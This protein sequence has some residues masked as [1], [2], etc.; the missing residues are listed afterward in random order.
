MH[1][2]IYKII[3]TLGILLTFTAFTCTKTFA[4]KIPE[5]I[6]SEELLLVSDE[7][8]PLLVTGGDAELKG[9]KKKITD[10]LTAKLHAAQAA[11]KLPFTLKEDAETY[12]HEGLFTDVEEEVP[13]ALIPLAIM[14]DS[15]HVKHQLQDNRCRQFVFGNLQRRLH[16]QQLDDGRRYSYQ[17][18]YD[19]GR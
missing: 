9:Y 2:K 6:W 12:E 15:L 4:A 14:A 11:G 1:S 13:V 10:A 16:C 8:N 3:L 5:V 19:F 18:L 7:T 17:R